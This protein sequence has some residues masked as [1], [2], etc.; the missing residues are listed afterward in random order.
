MQDLRS[1][2]QLRHGLGEFGFDLSIDDLRA[3]LQL[4]ALRGVDVRILVPDVGDH[5]VILGV[6]AASWA[7]AEFSRVDH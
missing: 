5:A 6:A 1:E 2:P 3:A 7:E 4:A